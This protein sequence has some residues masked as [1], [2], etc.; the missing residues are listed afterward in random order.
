M[1]GTSF[2]MTTFTFIPSINTLPRFLI[3]ARIFT[4][5]FSSMDGFTSVPFPVN[6]SFSSTKGDTTTF[7]PMLTDC[8]SAS[9]MQNSTSNQ[10]S[11]INVQNF[12]F[13]CW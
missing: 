11:S 12:S 1:S 10:V 8:N 7:C 4:C 3:L 13:G 5:P 6:S 2:S 9:K